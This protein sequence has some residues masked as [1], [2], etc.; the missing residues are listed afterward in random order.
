MNKY[1]LRI[2]ILIAVIL[3]TN[4][5]FAASE[6]NI[7][8]DGKAVIKEAKVMQIAGTTL[9][10]RLYWGDAY[11]RLTIK[12]NDKT[13]ILRSG[14]NEGS[15]TEFKVGDLVNTEGVLESGGN[16]L[17]LLPTKIQNIS[18]NKSERN[19]SGVIR[20]ILQNQGIFTLEVNSSTKINVKVPQGLTFKKGNRSLGSEA[21]RV[22]DRVLEVKGEYDANSSTLTAKS[23]TVFVDMS[24]YVKKVHTAK[25]ESSDSNNESIINISINNVVFKA[26]LGKST[27]IINASRKAISLKRF[28]VGDNLRVLG[29]IRESDD[30][31][32]DAEIIRNLDI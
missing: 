28:E 27:E 24:Q 19:Y 1:C 5:A 2:I 23:L 15:L 16:T 17:S 31:Q 3:L 6:V 32:I 12:G 11:V 8:R 9:F 10:T 13:K 30:P 7:S 22:G 20:D 25:F 14:G 4:K 21:L 26:Y 18:V 29:K